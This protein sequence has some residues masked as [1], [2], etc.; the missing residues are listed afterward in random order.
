MQLKAKPSEPKTSKRVLLNNIIMR[1]VE[2]TAIVTAYKYS[3]IARV[4][5]NAKPVPERFVAEIDTRNGSPKK[6]IGKSP[7]QVAKLVIANLKSGGIESFN[8]STDPKKDGHARLRESIVPGLRPSQL[9]KP[10]AETIMTALRD[11]KQK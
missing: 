6:L 4:A 9:S 8:F 2:R 1:R 5:R 3:P 7:G 10:E 11:Y